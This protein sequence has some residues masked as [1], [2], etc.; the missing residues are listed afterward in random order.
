MRIRHR[1]TVGVAACIAA[2]ASLIAVPGVASAA[3]CG[4]ANAGNG[5]SLP[6]LPTG[7][8]GGD[9]PGPTAEGPQ[10]KLPTY[11]DGTSAIISWVTG[12]RGPNATFSRFGISGTDLSIAWDNGSG[13]TLMAFGDTFGDC[14]VAGKQ[15][16]HNVLLRTD[17]TDLSNGLTV[18][19]GVPG[20][21]TSGASVAAGSPRFA[22]QMIGAI[23]WPGVE[24]TTIPTAAISIGGKQ[25]VNYMSVRS[26]GSAGVWDTNFSAIAVSSDNGQTWVTDPSTLRVNSPVAVPLPDGWPSV[27]P[28]DAKFQQG[29]YVEGHGADAGWIFQYGTP[30]GRYGAAYVARF[31]PSDVLNLSAYEYWTGSTWSSN[32]D[33]VRAIVGAPVTEMSVAWSAY[34]GKY[35]MVDSPLNVHLRT[36]DRPQGPWSLPRPL[37]PS[38]IGVYAPMMLPSSPALRGT[39][40]EL[41]MNASRWGDYNVLLLRSRLRR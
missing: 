5:S 14:T 8:L 26:W 3:P 20:D 16:R 1:L 7:S 39:G 32:V 19:D 27:R 17:D 37:F 30:N 10:G 4:T 11:N 41:Y 28:D 29:A 6:F 13:Q 15:W 33:D 31:R 34:L 21:V 12:P 25:Y 23:G 24:V 18:A 22:R 35:V 2:T 9:E 36:A 40:P 38:T